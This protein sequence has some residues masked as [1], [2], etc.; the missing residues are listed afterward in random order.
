VGARAAAEVLVIAFFLLL[1]WMGFAILE[2]LASDHLVSLSD[3]PV[4]WVQ[5]VIPISAVLIVAAELISL[6]AALALARAGHAV[7]SSGNTSH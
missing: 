7:S 2:V 4:A 1:G 3:V 5:S 6:P